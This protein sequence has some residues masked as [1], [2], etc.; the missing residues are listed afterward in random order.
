[1]A[2]LLPLSK[3]I[4]KDMG[5]AV[6]KSIQVNK[7]LQRGN[8]ENALNE[9]KCLNE[10]LK[11][12]HEKTGRMVTEADKCNAQIDEHGKRIERL[13]DFVKKYQPKLD[14]L[15]EVEIA[16]DFEYQLAKYI[17]PRG[18]EIGS[19]E[20]FQNLKQWL[21]VNRKIPN[22]DGNK[23]WNTLPEKIRWTEEHGNVLRRM[24]NFKSTNADRPYVKDIRTM[25]Q[26]LEILN[27]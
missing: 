6:Q 23:K 5:N 22:H 14:K 16:N 9:T 18:T 4:H 12:T 26:Q 2:A 11:A 21:D 8:K 7:T 20:I 3:E 1:M 13:E 15:N 25:A 24:L 17:Y 10:N 19:N 27:A